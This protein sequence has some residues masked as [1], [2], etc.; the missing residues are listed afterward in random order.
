[1][2]QIFILF[3]WIHNHTCSFCSGETVRLRP[4]QSENLS[5]T[6]KDTQS[7]FVNQRTENFSKN[8]EALS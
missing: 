2:Q 5:L 3:E 4:T 8:W 7:V 1:M 6:D